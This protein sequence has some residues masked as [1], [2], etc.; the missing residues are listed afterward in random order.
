MMAKQ[1]I[2]WKGATDYLRDIFHKVETVLVSEGPTLSSVRFVL[3]S[4]SYPP[5]LTV[6][7]INSRV[8][9]G[10]LIE[11]KTGLHYAV[12]DREGDGV[13]SLNRIAKMELGKKGQAI[14]DT[15]KEVA[16]SHDLTY[17]GVNQEGKRERS[18]KPEY[19]RFKK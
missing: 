11:D 7:F 9:R 16:R 13:L 15:L 18:F 2:D 4:I 1:E 14:G 10:K 17:P 8:D 6:D 5:R 12:L 3:S 19:E